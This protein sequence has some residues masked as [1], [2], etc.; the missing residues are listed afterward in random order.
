MPSRIFALCLAGIVLIGPLAV[1]LF[2]PAIPA[3]KA[4]FQ[5]SE[6]LAQ[7]TFS[8][9]I[10]AL[11]ISTLAYGTLSDRYGRRP[12]LLGGL[13]LF[14]TGC[15]ILA[16][17]S[18]FA[19]LLIGRVVQAVGA[20]CAMTLVR[21]IARDAYGQAQLARAIAYL[22]MFYTLGPMISPVVGG[23]L[24]DHYGWRAAF[25]FALALGALVATG[26]WLVLH[27]THR[28]STGRLDPVTVL[29]SYVDPFRNP[30]FAAYVLQTGFSTGVFYTLVAA[31]AVIMKEHLGRPAAEYGLYFLVFPIGFLLGNVLSTRLIPR[32]SGEALVLAGS[33]LVIV[34]TA[35]QA[36]LLVA[37]HVNPLT[38]FLP[39]FALT[40][41]QGV[42]LPSAQSG[43][44]A[45]VPSSIGTAAGIGV[46]TQ[47]VIGAA[48]AQLYGVLASGSMVPLAGVMLLSA[49]MVIVCGLI[50]WRLARRR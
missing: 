6:A 28:G 13:A 22:T 20:G 50:P 48:M 26:A 41:A 11:A 19:M 9:G 31:S 4:E 39:G 43:A 46:F 2:L 16:T 38:L 34:F 12:V 14:L 37:G 32:V 35:L 30:L 33:L 27:E 10:L 25:V 21:S 5:L 36:A 8:I 44:I 17:A 45:L 1:H 29:R 23:L 3:V 42:A 7:L 49:V 40:F 15:A 24:I 18:S 47:Q